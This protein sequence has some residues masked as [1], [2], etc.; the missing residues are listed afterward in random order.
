L[1]IPLAAGYQI[2]QRVNLLLVVHSRPVVL[3]AALVLLPFLLDRPLRRL[4]MT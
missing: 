3:I 4:A 1:T 2:G